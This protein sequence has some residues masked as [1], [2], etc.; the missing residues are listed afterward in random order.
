MTKSINQNF[1]QNI[2]VISIILTVVF[3]VINISLYVINNNYLV[4]KVEEENNA[5][6]TITTHII[7]ENEVSV[8]LEYIEH[9]THIHKV[10]IEVYD[11]NNEMLFSSKLAHL[12]TSSYVI[13]TAKGEYTIYIDNTDSV[14]VNRVEMNNI[15]VNVSL[16]IIYFISLF[17]MVKLNRN[18]SNQINKDITNII[19]LIRDENKL[20]KNFNHTEFEYIYTTVNNYLEDI[21]LLTDQKEMNMKGLAHDIKTPLT[22]IYSYFE[23]VRR[24]E[25]V[26]EKDVVTAFESSIRINDLLNDLIEDK[27]RSSLETINLSELIKDKM[28]EY[29]SI[30]N[31]KEIK[32]ISEIEDGVMFDWNLKDFYRVIDNIVSNAY[33]YSKSD[34][35]LHVNLINKD[36]IV[37][38]VRSTP[39]DIESFD[40]SK[41]FNK[42]YR[43]NQENVKNNYGKGYGLYICRLLLHSIQ[44]EI[45]VEIIENDVEFTI[46]L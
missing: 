35:K 41:V 46:L 27:E 34:S 12:Y 32:I 28:N 37:I 8:A 3:L 31:N 11:E 15:Y 29:V 43:G 39:I 38:K 17:I 33:Y 4:N 5:F 21:D 42:G 2:I 25:K 18:N 13:D 10:N 36:N 23:R 45:K 40:V 44:G 7:N 6:L 26:S 14:T 9:Y 24:N 20:Q 22:L 30:F 16:L 19:E 1:K